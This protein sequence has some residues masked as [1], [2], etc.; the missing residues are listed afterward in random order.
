MDL[1]QTELFQ[2]TQEA[3]FEPRVLSD[4]TGGLLVTRRGARVLGIFLGGV[5]QNGAPQNLLWANPKTVGTKAAAADTVAR[6]EWN[7][8]GD[9]VWVAPEIELHFTNPNKPSHAEYAVPPDLD[10]GKYVIERESPRAI[11]FGASGAAPNLVSMRQFKFTAHRE[12]RLCAPPLELGGL[13]YVGY[14]LSSDLHVV[15][16]DRP[17]ACYGLWQLMMV[18][19]GGTIFIPTRGTAEQVDYFQT[20]VAA[21]CRTAADHVAFPV[22]GTTQ[23]KLGLRPDQVRGVM[24]YY[25]VIGEVATLIVRQVAV[26]AGA[27]YADYPAHARQRR[28][29]ALQFYNDTSAGFGEMEYHSTAAIA[30]NLFSVRDVSRT[31]CFAGQPARVRGVAA[32]LLGING[33]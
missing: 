11:S 13:N 30:E 8:G 22:T 17:D 25:R 15:A 10:P 4:Y 32:T 12:I 16:P 14:E 5:P 21:H 3:G 7:T 23:Q 9:R 20:N 27:A 29:V 18:P 19:A 28:D 31:W 6:G 1:R 24:G 2:I 26:F 33:V